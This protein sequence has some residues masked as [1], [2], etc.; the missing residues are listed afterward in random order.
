VSLY[1]SFASSQGITPPCASS[2]ILLM[3]VVQIGKSL[4]FVHFVL[5]YVACDNGAEHLH[6]EQNRAAVATFA[7]LVG[8]DGDAIGARQRALHANI[9]SESVDDS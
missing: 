9:F 1:S 5:R 8:E 3:R 2:R 6:G 7:D 4:G